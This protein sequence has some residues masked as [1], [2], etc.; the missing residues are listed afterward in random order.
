ME[1]KDINIQNGMID[2]ENFYD[3]MRG[4]FNIPSGVKSTMEDL[5]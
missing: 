3:K 2:Y 1:K 4:Q 5:K